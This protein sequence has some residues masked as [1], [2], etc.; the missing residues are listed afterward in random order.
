MDQETNESRAD[1]S[2]GAGTGG[3]DREWWLALRRTVMRL[4]D[5]A[6]SAAAS[7]YQLRSDLDRLFG[8]A[9]ASELVTAPAAAS[10][11]MEP[12]RVDSPSAPVADEGSA[13]GSATEGQGVTSLDG[14]PD[15]AEEDE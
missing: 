14:P 1:V 13:S 9:A 8:S 3:A 7:D 11:A 4:L 15:G 5:L 12:A 6:E 2:S 10:T